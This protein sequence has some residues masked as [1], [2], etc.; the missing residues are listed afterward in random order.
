[1]GAP[2]FYT[3][4]HED[5]G[6]GRRRV[7]FQNDSGFTGN[8]VKAVIGP[9]QPFNARCSALCIIYITNLS[10]V[11]NLSF[12]HRRGNHVPPRTE[13]SH[14]RGPIVSLGEMETSLF[15]S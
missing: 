3:H 12:E 7:F 1:M 4:C 13:C 6:E 8:R 2:T 5:T 15:H 9:T 14:L 10:S 11:S